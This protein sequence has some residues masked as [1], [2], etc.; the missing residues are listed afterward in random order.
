VYQ[1]LVSRIALPLG[2][3]KRFD[4]LVK[5]YAAMVKSRFKRCLLEMWLLIHVKA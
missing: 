3:G 1:I 2:A 5:N 4:K